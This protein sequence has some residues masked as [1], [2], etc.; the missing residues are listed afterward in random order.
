MDGKAKTDITILRLSSVRLTNIREKHEVLDEIINEYEDY[1]EENKPPYCDYK[2]TAIE[3]K[4]NSPHLR[5]R[6]WVNKVIKIIQSYK[7]ATF[8]ELLLDLHADKKKKLLRENRRKERNMKQLNIP[9][10]ERNEQ[11]ISVLN[12]KFDLMMNIIVQQQS[13]MDQMRNEI[14]MKINEIHGKLF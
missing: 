10:E 2:T 5:F 9:T 6:N 13:A 4:V 8:T 3:E 1:T 14:L 7:S 11:A 12:Q